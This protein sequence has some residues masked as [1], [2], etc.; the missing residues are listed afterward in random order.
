M[1]FVHKLHSVTGGLRPP[2]PP[3]EFQTFFFIFQKID[4]WIKTAILFGYKR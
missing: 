3:A 2:D 4:F 1:K